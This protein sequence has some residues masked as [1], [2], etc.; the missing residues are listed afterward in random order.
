MGIRA[1]Q[2]KEKGKKLRQ[3]AEE[4][5]RKLQERMREGPTTEK[6][7]NLMMS[8]EWQIAERI[9]ARIEPEEKAVDLWLAEEGL[10]ATRRA[11]DEEAA[12]RTSG[13][14]RRKKGGL[15]WISL[16]D[17]CV[18]SVMNHLDGERLVML[19]SVNRRLRQFVSDPGLWKKACEGLPGFCEVPSLNIVAGEEGYKGWARVY[20]ALSNENAQI[21]MNSQLSLPNCT[22]MT[23]TGKTIQFTGHIGAD[24]A[25]RAAEGWL[26]PWDV[27]GPFPGSKFLAKAALWARGQPLSWHVPPLLAQTEESGTARYICSL[28]RYFEVTVHHANS[29]STQDSGDEGR[30]CVAIGVSNTKFCLDGMQPGWDIHSCAY[31]SD[32]GQVFFGNACVSC[33]PKFGA[34]DTVGCGMCADGSLFFTKNGRFLSFVREVSSQLSKGAGRDRLLY[35]TIGVDSLCPIEIN[36]GRTPFQYQFAEV[37]DD[38]WTRGSATVAKLSLLRAMAARANEDDPQACHCVIS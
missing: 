31:H 33:L 28:C 11:E 16:F 22:G 18:W 37:L 30:W 2:M 14:V 32:D 25:V 35:P 24:R 34:G 27:E 6:A 1:E 5:M 29:R 9:R 7:M 15:D 10:V 8:M 19:L 13:L 3:A 26:L 20:Q 38:K 36:W 12:R 21:A 17:D 23:S 4:A